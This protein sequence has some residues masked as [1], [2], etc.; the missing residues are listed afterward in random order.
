MCI[1]IL[2]Y[3]NRLDVCK[4]L[5][6][7]YITRNGILDNYH[8]FNYHLENDNLIL[9]ENIVIPYQDTVNA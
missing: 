6:D 5:I 1:F 8:S 2:N 3:S 9:N 7:K 4:K